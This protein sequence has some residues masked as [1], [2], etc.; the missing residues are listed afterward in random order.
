[1]RGE[2]SGAEELENRQVHGFAEAVEQE[3][4]QMKS[5]YSAGEEEVVFGLPKSLGDEIQG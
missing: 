2:N 5:W 3:L 4:E 1:M